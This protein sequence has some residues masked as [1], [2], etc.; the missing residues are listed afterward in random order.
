MISEKKETTFCELSC[1]TSPEKVVFSSSDVLNILHEEENTAAGLVRLTAERKLPAM[2]PSVVGVGNI[3]PNHL[4]LLV[5]VGEFHPV[6]PE[7][8]K[9]RDI[10]ALRQR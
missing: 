7:F 1:V 10:K 8:C 6:S 4:K 9:H 5:E 3:S 2:A